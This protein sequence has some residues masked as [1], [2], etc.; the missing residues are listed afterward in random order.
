M[1]YLIDGHNLIAALP[2]I[3]LEDEHDEVDLVLK[4]RA[5]AGRQRRKIV[6][7]FDGGIPG[8]YSP[9]LSSPN[10]R[11]VFAARHRTTADRIIRERVN[12]L[13]DPINWT[14]VSS[15]YAVLYQAE[16]AGAKTMTAE[17]FADLL[18]QPTAES[19][20]KPQI[21]SQAEIEDWLQVF[22]DLEPPAEIARP[23]VAPASRPTGSNSDHAESSG[24]G[25]KRPQ[26]TQ[27]PRGHTARTIAEQVGLPQPPP[28]PPSRSVGKPSEPSP[29]DVDAWLEVFH[30]LPDSEL[31]KP[32]VR[33]RHPEPSKPAPPPVR[34]DGELTP[35]E[36]DAWLNEFSSA[37]EASRKETSQP[38]T[39]APAP[40]KLARKKRNLVAAEEEEQANGLTKEDRELWRR[41]FGKET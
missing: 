30:D 4:L 15:D 9:Q 28:P 22:T 10:V 1:P 32:V 24:I 37:G 11:I 20:E 23:K 17:G 34:K 35:K 19:P 39:P 31:P 2:D 26:A 33:A 18:S 27:Q 8:G 25:A 14:V 36:V 3:H 38:T 7:I 13:S 40:N 12:K 29:E 41:L 5:W 16:T 6:V 21:V